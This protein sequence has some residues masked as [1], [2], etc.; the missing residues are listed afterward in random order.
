MENKFKIDI[1]RNIAILQTE[2]T[3]RRFRMFKDS[4]GTK[5]FTSRG[6]IYLTNENSEVI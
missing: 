6:V 5:I 4:I 1:K 3:I 2:D